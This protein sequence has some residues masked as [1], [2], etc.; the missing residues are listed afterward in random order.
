[1]EA[2]G[3]R[4][5]AAHSLG[6]SPRTVARRLAA[7]PELAMS[8]ADSQALERF[9][10][11]KALYES[12]IDGNVYAQIH[13]LKLWGWG[14]TVTTPQPIAPCLPEIEVRLMV[15][16]EPVETGGLDVEQP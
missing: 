1:M 16:G 11:F 4:S 14:T 5:R 10:V 13:L 6:I 7:K 3:S 9:F 12:A 8:E 2:L 15:D